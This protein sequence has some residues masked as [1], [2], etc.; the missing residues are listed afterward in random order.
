[1]AYHSLKVEMHDGDIRSC[2]YVW[3]M[4]RVY[5]NGFLTTYI[6]IH[7]WRFIGW[8]CYIELHSMELHTSNRNSHSGFIWGKVQEVV[9]LL[10]LCQLSHKIFNYIN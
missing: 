10:H 3:L 9:N 2:G 5:S 7:V 6:S 4:E 1:M 8:I